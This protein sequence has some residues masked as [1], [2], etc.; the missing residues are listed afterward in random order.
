MLRRA[1]SLLLLSVALSA[2]LSAEVD[3]RFAHPGADML[4]GFNLRNLI[5]SPVGVPFREAL[6]SLGGIGRDRQPRIDR[7]CSQGLK[8]K[9]L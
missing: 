4:V 7:R 9:G 3:W 8:S 6:T 2:A 1:G 5:N